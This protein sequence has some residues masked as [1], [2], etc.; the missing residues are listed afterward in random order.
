MLIILRVRVRRRARADRQITLT[1]NSHALNLNPASPSDPRPRPLRPGPPHDDLDISA[2]DTPPPD[3]SAQIASSP[4]R[5]L[6]FGSWLPADSHSGSTSSWSEGE[7][8]QSWSSTGESHSP[9]L[10]EIDQPPPG[11]KLSDEDGVKKAAMILMAMSRQGFR[12]RT[13]GSG[14]VDAAKGELL[15]TIDTRVYVSPSPAD[16]QTTESRMF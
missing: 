2:H 9:S 5:S 3:G 12:P 1:G 13:Y 11:A 8:W 15:G 14:A 7:S 4:D 6:S 10:G 16:L